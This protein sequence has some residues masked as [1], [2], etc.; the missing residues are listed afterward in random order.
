MRKRER[1]RERERERARGGGKSKAERSGADAGWGCTA[2]G[3]AG[4]PL[5]A[6]PARRPLSVNRPGP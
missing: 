4:R 1:E 6:R 3:R 2:S 5:R